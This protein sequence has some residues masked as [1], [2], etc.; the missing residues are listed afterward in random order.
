MLQTV[1]KYQWI[2]LA[3][4]VR[5]DFM[6]DM[7]SDDVIRKFHITRIEHVGLGCMADEAIRKYFEAHGIDIRVMPYIPEEF[8]NPLFLRMFCEGYDETENGT[9]M[10]VTTIQ[11]YG[12]YIR[13]INKKL[14]AVYEYSRELP[15]LDEILEAFVRRSYRE[16]ERNKLRKRDAVGL[17]A[18]IA[19]KYQI[20][21]TI[22]FWKESYGGMTKR[23]TAKERSGL[24]KIS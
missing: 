18:E 12:N 8:H 13:S 24:Q 7:I 2:G 15:V 16:G 19:G 17:V 21:T 20:R 3:V 4:S 11:I 9:E 1:A 6:P 23:Y 5:T 22:Y 10:K 14:S